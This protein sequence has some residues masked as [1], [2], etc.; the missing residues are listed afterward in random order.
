VAIRE[1]Y[2]LVS[3]VN[4]SV[5]NLSTE[6]AYAKRVLSAQYGED[7]V[8]KNA[9][10]MAHPFRSLMLVICGSPENKSNKFSILS[11]Y[12]DIID[13]ETSSPDFN[14]MDAATKEFLVHLANM[15]NTAMTMTDYSDLPIGYRRTLRNGI[16]YISVTHRGVR[17]L[18]GSL[19]TTP[20]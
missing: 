17:I 7:F 1:V 8:A 2:G 14:R 16:T 3:G 15:L 11:W 9:C 18:V 12:P 20:A 10:I 6:A 4:S 5:A 19:A 13:V